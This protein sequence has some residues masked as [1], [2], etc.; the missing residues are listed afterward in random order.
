MLGFDFDGNKKTMQLESKKREFLLA[1]LHKWIR[2]ASS[3]TA[4]IEFAEFESVI[5]KIRNGFM[6]IPGGKGLLTTCNRV[7]AKR[8]RRVFLHRNQRLTTALKDMR[9]LIREAT[10]NPTK[11]IELVMGPP[12]YVGVKDASIHGVGDFIVGQG[13]SCLPTVFRME[14]P[15]WVKEEVLKTNAGQKGTLTN[16]DLEMAGMLLLWLVMEEVCDLTAGTHVALFSDNAPT[17]IRALALR[18]KLEGA[19][20]LSTLH[21]AGDKNEMTDIP[22]RSF[23]SE[24]KW[25][26]PEDKFESELFDLYNS[27]FHLPKQNLWTVFRPSKKI[28]S[29]IFFALRTEVLEMDEWRRLPKP[30]SNNAWP[31]CWIVRSDVTNSNLMREEE[32]SGDPC[33]TTRRRGIVGCV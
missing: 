5:S 23:R 18:L 15:Q 1:V 31:F 2:T 29:L 22:S 12:D 24:A 32:H 19:S 9:T 17:L 4:G 11:C 26:S 6:C 13:K 25:F 16:S 20:P 3:N 21:I 30:G 33:G 7:I 28:M 10:A 8:P 27:Q 14:W